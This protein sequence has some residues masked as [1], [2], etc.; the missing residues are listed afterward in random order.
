[1]ALNANCNRNY[2]L[3]QIHPFISCLESASNTMCLSRRLALDKRSYAL[4]Q[5]PTLITA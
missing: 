1:M 5:S 2:L 3:V 4:M